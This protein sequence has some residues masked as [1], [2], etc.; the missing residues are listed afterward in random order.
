MS[1][2]EE[3]VYTIDLSKV[4]L[5][6]RS[7]R[8]KRAINMIKEYAMRHMK[9]GEVRIDEELNQLIW[10]RGIRDP[11]RRVRVKMVRD[12]DGIIRIKPYTEK[13]S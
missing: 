5:T 9:S 10:S 12:A 4:T 6:P 3:R 11:P 13:E 7:R 2:S 8:S 1:E